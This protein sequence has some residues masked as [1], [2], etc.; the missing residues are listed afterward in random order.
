MGLKSGEKEEKRIYDI[1]KARLSESGEKAGYAY[2]CLGCGKE[3]PVA[4]IPATANS[5]K[6]YL[7]ILEDHYKCPYCGSYRI[8]PVLTIAEKNRLNP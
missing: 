1:R 7:R 4:D 6:D 8:E 2:K 5:R 3:F